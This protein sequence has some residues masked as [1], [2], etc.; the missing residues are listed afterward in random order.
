MNEPERCDGDGG[1]GGL[2]TSDDGDGRAGKA[3][4]PSQDV[5]AIVMDSLMF[6][7][8][9]YNVH[10]IY[11]YFKDF[12]NHTIFYKLTKNVFEINLFYIMFK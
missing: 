4:W 10:L 11:V 2:M 6:R 8:L 12:S 1:V 3:M 5:S 7:T 9:K